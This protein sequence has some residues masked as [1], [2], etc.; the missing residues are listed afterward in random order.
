LV[1]FFLSNISRYGGSGVKTSGA[2]RKDHRLC[3]ESSSLF[4]AGFPEIVYKQAM[5][6]EPEKTGSSFNQEEETDI[7]L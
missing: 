6:I 5:M 2:Y 3:H 1:T 4:W 7:N